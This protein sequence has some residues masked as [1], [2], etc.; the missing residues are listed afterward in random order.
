MSKHERPSLRIHEPIVKDQIDHIFADLGGNS[1]L[2]LSPLQRAEKIKKYLEKLAESRDEATTCDTFL[3]G[4][5]LVVIK[6]EAQPIKRII[7]K[8]LQQMTGVEIVLVNDTKYT[9]KTFLAVYGDFL[10]SPSPEVGVTFPALLFAGSTSTITAILFRHL[11]LGE[12]YQLKASQLPE[13]MFAFPEEENDPQVIFKKLFVGSGDQ[14][15]QTLRYQIRLY[16]NL[17]G[18]GSIDTN[19]AQSFDITGELRNR[20]PEQNLRTF[21]GLHCPTNTSECLKQ[22]GIY[23]DDD[24]IKQVMPYFQASGQ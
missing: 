18:F 16:L 4:V 19:L 5:G 11:R 1:F 7:M 6:P 20:S 21:N 9:L 12:Y 24:Q 8:S 10:Q 22:V 13:S 17:L 15:P 3:P 14:H 2:E 23:F